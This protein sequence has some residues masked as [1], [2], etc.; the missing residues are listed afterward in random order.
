MNWEEFFNEGVGG[1]PN[2][3]QR[4]IGN[5]RIVNKEPTE[6]IKIFQELKVDSLINSEE[7]VNRLNNVRVDYGN[8][9][10]MFTERKERLKKSK[11]YEIQAISWREFNSE[12]Y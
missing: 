10:L 2:F 3:K 11:Y 1:L 4:L 5:K 6:L 12:F 8:G 9:F 7:L